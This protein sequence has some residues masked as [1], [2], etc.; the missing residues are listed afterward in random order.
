MDWLK[1][2]YAV[3]PVSTLPPS[4]TNG[5]LVLLTSV[6]PNVYYQF[7][8]SVNPPNGAWV[9]LGPV[10][11]FHF[12]NLPTGQGPIQ[13]YDTKSTQGVNLF[14]VYDQDTPYPAPLLVTDQ[15]FIVKKDLAV[16]GNILSGQGAMIFGYGWTGSGSPT[17][18]IAQ[19]PQIGRAHV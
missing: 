7:D 9:N 15:G 8:T 10:G 2:T 3:D 12:G 14:V 6:N 1:T 4:G 19:S 16:G 5:Q 13:L 18:P 11:D 17:S